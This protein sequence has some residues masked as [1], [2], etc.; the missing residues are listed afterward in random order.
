MGN[1]HKEH[2]QPAER[3]QRGK[4]KTRAMVRGAWHTASHPDAGCAVGTAEKE[5]SPAEACRYPSRCSQARP[6]SWTWRQLTLSTMSRARGRLS[7]ARR[8][9]SGKCCMLCEQRILCLPPTK[10]HSPIFGWSHS[11]VVRWDYGSLGLVGPALVPRWSH[12]GIGCAP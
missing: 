4:G 6:S 2:G 1:I 3:S 5:R 7:K 10:P 9:T 12:F 8:R 11:P